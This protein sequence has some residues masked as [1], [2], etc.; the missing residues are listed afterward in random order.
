MLR[1]K[2][3]YTINGFN[4]FVVGELVEK[5]D[6]FCSVLSDINGAVVKIAERNIDE[7][8]EFGGES[9]GERKKE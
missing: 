7:Y 3:S 9:N 1:V 6:S 4:K 5:T 8:I 2:V